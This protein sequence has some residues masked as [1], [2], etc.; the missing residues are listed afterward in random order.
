[1]DLSGSWQYIEDTA[2]NRL[3][4]NKTKRHVSNYGEGIEV[5]GVAG[6]LLVR[7][8]LGLPE[9]VHEGF[10]HGVD[11]H[12]FGMRL[13]VQATVLTPNAN[14]RFLQWPIW[15]KARAKYV[16]MTVVD[17]INR[18]G[19]VIGYAPKAEVFTAP[20]NAERLTPCHEIPFTSSHL[21]GELIVEG[22]RRRTFAAMDSFQRWKLCVGI[23]ILK[24][25][26]QARNRD[27]VGLAGLILK[28]GCVEGFST[29]TI[30]PAV[31]QA[32]M[33]F[34]ETS[35]VCAGGITTMLI[36]AS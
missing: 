23:V 17:P 2:R 5:I 32:G 21:A 36:T 26:Q 11:I 19:T 30:S 33:T 3:A 4:H 8:F 31:D 18:L 34:W 12:Y 35:S 1:M 14:Y 6:E 9:Q 15:K 29:C 27:G 25:I 20:I 16:I 13:D 24:T 10:D 22:C 7:R 28:D